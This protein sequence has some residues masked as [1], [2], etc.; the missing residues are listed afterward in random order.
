MV[1]GDFGVLD[2]NGEHQLFRYRLRKKQRN[3]IT[4]F[5]NTKLLINYVIEYLKGNY[6][7]KNKMLWMN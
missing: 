2:F 5:V 3:N 1:Q 4:A 7:V 6:Y